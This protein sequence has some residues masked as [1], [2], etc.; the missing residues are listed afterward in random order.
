[1]AGYLFGDLYNIGGR[2]KELDPALQ[3]NFDS[4]A[5][6]YRV[7]RGKHQVMTVPA[8]KLDH[9]VIMALHEGDLHRYRRLEDYIEFLEARE[10][11][12]E[13]RKERELSNHIESVYLDNFDQLEGIKHFSVGGK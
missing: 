11:E 9:R 3:I 1:M 2:V 12:A 8:G 10:M 7:M 13:R 4:R 5:F 6:L